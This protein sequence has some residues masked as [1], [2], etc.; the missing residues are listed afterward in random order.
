MG[1]RSVCELHDGRTG[2]LS[3]GLERRYTRRFRVRT[4]SKAVGPIEVMFAPGVPRLYDSYQS[5]GTGEFDSFALCRRVTPT[6]DAD[7]WFTWVVECE[8][9]T[10][11][12]TPQGQPENPGQPGSGGG[13]GASGDP[14]LEPPTVEWGAQ[15]R[16]VAFMEDLGDPDAHEASEEF[17]PRTLL[18]SAGQPFDPVPT[19]EVSHLT[20][21]VERNEAEFDQLK[22]RKYKGVVNKDVFLGYAAGLWFL[23]HITGR[24]VYKG[25]YQYARVR[26]EFWLAPTV[27][28][29]D[30]WDNLDLLD[31]GLCRKG[32][33]NGPPIPIMVNGHPISQP[34]LLKNGF[35]LPPP[36]I[37]N[38]DIGPQF[39]RFKRYR[40]VPFAPL[41]ITI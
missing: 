19:I 36:Q 29:K 12:G 1:F 38:P 14:T 4:D 18:N 17:Y 40:R 7:D 27:D 32:N 21:T 2:G 41:K 34:A 25:A 16:E 30:H 11:G 13:S 5:Y 26:Y 39:L 37:I 15:S 9:D 8:Y 22:A 23:K 20:L 3:E 6:Q 28:E 10:T 33:D 31:Q 24:V 35:P